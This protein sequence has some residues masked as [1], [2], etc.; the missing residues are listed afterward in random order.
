MTS[1]NIIL[2]L[3]L[4]KSCKELEKMVEE[5]A[6]NMSEMGCQY[7]SMMRMAQPG[8]PCPDDNT[9]KTLLRSHQYMMTDYNQTM[10]M[11]DGM[12]KLPTRMVSIV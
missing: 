1:L 2:N 4:P 7:E 8:V 9:I 6:T 12:E 10:P 3:Q 11:C 5:M